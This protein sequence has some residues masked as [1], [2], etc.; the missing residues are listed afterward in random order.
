M[1]FALEENS[2][3]TEINNKVSD[4]NYNLRAVYKFGHGVAGVPDTTASVKNLASVGSELDLLPHLATSGPTLIGVDYHNLR[5][6]TV[7]TSGSNATDLISTCKATNELTI[8]VI[9]KNTND[10]EIEL[11]EGPVRILTLSSSSTLGNFYLGQNYDGGEMRSVYQAAVRT[12]DP[13]GDNNGRAIAIAPVAIQANKKQHIYFTRDSNGDGT[14]YVSNPGTNTLIQRPPQNNFGGDFSD[15]NDFKISVGNEPSFLNLNNE[16]ADV[17]GTD[18]HTGKKDWAGNLYMVAIYCKALTAKQI[19]GNSAPQSW[20]PEVEPETN[21]NDYLVQAIDFNRSSALQLYKRLNGVSI[22]YFGVQTT[23]TGTRDVLGEMS[24]LISSGKWMDAADLAT[25]EKG[26][27]NVTLKDFAKK[28]SNRSETV[29]APFND[30]AALII[31]TTVNDSTYDIQDLLST[32]KTFVA[33]SGLAVPSDK[34]DDL[35]K[36][37][38]HYE[39]LENLGFDLE[40]SMEEQPQELYDGNGN[41]SVNQDAAGLLTT[42]A[43]LSE[44]AIAGTNRRIVEFSFQEFLCQPILKW[45][46]NS[47]DDNYVAKDV[48]RAPGGDTNK[49]NSTCKACHTVMD[50]LR[51]AFSFLTFENN[52]VKSVQTMS[53]FTTTNGNN[54]DDNP[55]MENQIHVYNGVVSKYNRNQEDGEGGVNVGSPTNSNIFRN[56]ATTGLNKTYFGWD[57]SGADSSG[58]IEGSGVNAF[59]RML[60]SSDAFPK[61]MTRRVFRSV[62]K[63][64]PLGTESSFLDTVATE[65]VDNGIGNNKLRYLFKRIATSPECMGK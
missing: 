29:N 43:F 22:P 12:A 47:K 11:R 60:A 19:L 3:Q 41:I 4:S 54:P 32:N 37:N 34:I 26:F 63:R 20:I 9:L 21:A 27:Y 55:E 24:A 15:W 46:D 56:I 1:S 62:C 40:I 44:H 17:T 61:C 49:Y 35:Q 53:A 6:P 42:R 58:V 25:R 50:S 5:T 7:L 48:D 23:T 30:F 52:F 51:P 18:Y 36:S 39:T 8:E 2:T 10:T 38:N 65:L 14:F 31:G 59:G 57:M 45:A 28:M 33:K 16:E 13:A 64:D